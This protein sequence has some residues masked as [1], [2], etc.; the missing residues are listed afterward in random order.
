MKDVVDAVVIGAGPNGLVAAATLARK[1]WD[2]AVL[3]RNDAPGGAVRSEALTKPGFVHDTFSAFYGLLHA[4]PV[5][6]ELELDRRVRWAH[7]DTPWSASVSPSEAAFIY[8][9]AERTAKGLEQLS[10]RDGDAWRDLARWWHTIGT[11]FFAATI[12]PVGALRPP[13][14]LLRKT[15]VRGGVDLARMMLAPVNEVAALRFASE[16]AR[17][18]L[19][20]GVTHSDLSAEAAGST[21]ASLILAMLAQ[22]VGMPVVCGGAQN[23]ADAFAAA[24]TDAGGD[25]ACGDAVARVVVERGRAL[26]VETASG[27]FVRA[28][29]AVLADTG[30]K[31]MI[32]LAG[33]DEFPARYLDGVRAFRYGT[34]VFKLDIALDGVTPWSVE[35]LRETGVVHITGSLDDMARANFDARHGTLPARPALVC[36]QQSIADPSRAPEGKHTLWV[37]THVP[38]RPARDGRD[39]GAGAELSGGWEGARDAFTER[40][41]DL[42]EAHAPG[43]RARVEAV[44]V[45]T[46]DDLERRNPNLVGGDVSGGSAAITQ[47]L[48]FRPVPGWFRYRTPVKALYLCSASTHP[49]GG[50]HGMSGRNAARRVLADARRPSG[51]LRTATSA[52]RAPRRD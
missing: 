12:A 32:D 28:R 49:G 23:L 38:A 42:V 20:S 33:T 44:A 52:R 19:A 41:L 25:V 18:L 51:I 50:V 5:F 31:A 35:Q 47:Q 24:V 34:G 46:P 36:G 1:G 29:H 13:L 45:H 26:G 22:T 16:A 48:V 40:V 17:A 15:G 6:R 9:D 8:L 3:E 30:P 10:A 2:V 37:E 27:R 21:P 14:R 7:F 11:R 43:F 4:T 39:G